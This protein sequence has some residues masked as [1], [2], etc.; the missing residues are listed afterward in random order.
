M[1]YAILICGPESSG[2]GFVNKIFQ[3]IFNTKNKYGDYKEINPKYN[4]DNDINDKEL[5]IL[6][7]IQVKNTVYTSSNNSKKIDLNFNKTWSFKLYTD[8]NNEDTYYIKHIG[9]PFGDFYPDIGNFKKQLENLGFNTKIIIPIRNYYLSLISS[10]RR[11]EYNNNDAKIYKN[12]T[13]IIINYLLK[14]ENPIILSYDSM[15]YLGMDYLRFFFKTHFN[16][17]DIPDIIIKDADKK[18]FT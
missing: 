13:K 2:T 5:L 4:D 3:T 17:K 12:I 1:K 6:K 18:Y 8:V 14:Y 7:N 16:I 10:I 9:I 15:L 11:F